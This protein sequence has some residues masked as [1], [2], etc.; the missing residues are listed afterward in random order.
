MAEMKQ[1]LSKLAERTIE[2]RVP[3]RNSE[4]SGSFQASFG[5]L[6]VFVI[7]SRNGATKNV[8]LSVQDKRGETIGRMSYSS[9][10]PDENSELESLYDLAQ[11]VA[12]DDPRL[13][14]L[15]DALDATPPVS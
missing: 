14:V 11:R 5:N 7:G 8:L 15:I 12:S 2:N 1:V 3:W 4:L 6:T 10:Y 9:T 13:D